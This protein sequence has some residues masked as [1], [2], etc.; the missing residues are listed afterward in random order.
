MAGSLVLVRRAPY[1]VGMES[2]GWLK[3]RDIRA[4]RVR[5]HID[6]QTDVP[7]IYHHDV[8]EPEVEEVLE[9]STEDFP[10]HAGARIAIGSTSAG[11]LLRVIYVPDSEPNS[12]F[13]ITAYDLRGK[14]LLAYRRRRRRKSA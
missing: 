1:E 5:Y 9:R 12:V 7:H 4:M 6:P 13:V 10:G 3:E 11:R 14:Q 8:C 2:Q